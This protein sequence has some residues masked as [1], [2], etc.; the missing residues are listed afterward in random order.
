MYIS[1]L[2]ILIFFKIILHQEGDKASK[3]QLVT[4]S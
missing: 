1:V 2:S 3:T 4:E